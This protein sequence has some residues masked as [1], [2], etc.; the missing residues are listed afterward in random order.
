MFRA[1]SWMLDNFGLAISVCGAGMLS[2][3]F[4]PKLWGW[5]PFASAAGLAVTFF[6]LL[7]YIA[8]RSAWLQMQPPRR[9]SIRK[10]RQQR[11]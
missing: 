9:R 4:A 7:I 2:M 1:W 10:R 6:G 11:L 5:S 8:V 3:V